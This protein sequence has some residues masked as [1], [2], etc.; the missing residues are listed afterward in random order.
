[1]SK[2][3]FS[4]LLLGAVLLPCVSGQELNESPGFLHRRAR[5]F[6]GVRLHKEKP[7]AAAAA[8]LNAIEKS[9]ALPLAP[10]FD[11]VW[12]SIGPRPTIVLDDATSAGP[13]IASGRVTSIAVDPRG[14]GDIVYIGAAHGGVWKTVDAG[15][16]WVPLTDDQPSLA[17]G[18][19][20][21]DPS[22]PDTV[23]AGT[24]EENFDDADNYF[25]AGILKTEDGGKTWKLLAS[26][27]FGGPVSAESGGAR[28]GTI[29][30][31]P[32]DS[33]ILLAA[34]DGRK[35]EHSGIYRSEDAGVTWKN[36][37]HG[38]PGTSVLFDPR[39]PA[40]LYAGLGDKSA[41]QASGIYKSTDGG[42][43][44][45]RSNRGVP[46][47]I[48]RVTLTIAASNPAILYAAIASPTTDAPLGVFK[49]TD[50]GAT[51]TSANGP[52]YCDQTCFWANTIQVSP[53]NPDLVFVA[54]LQV[55]MTRDGGKDWVSVSEG[56]NGNYI[57]WDVHAIVF[58]P[59]GRRV[60]VATDGGMYRADNVGDAQIRD[61]GWDNINDTLAITQFYPGCSGQV[62]QTDF[63]VCGTQDNGVQ[64][65]TGGSTWRMIG[66]GDGGFTAID[67][68]RPAVFYF[69]G[70]G[71]I[72]IFKSS[73]FTSFKGFLE[74]DSGLG[75]IDSDD[76]FLPPL[77]LDPAS[78]QRL[79]Y[80]CRSVFRTVDGGGR[81]QE[82]SKEL[83][84][85][86]AYTFLAV[87]PA[88]SSRVYAAASNG[89]VLVSDNATAAP[90]SVTWRTSTGLPKRGISSVVVDPMN[91]D[92]AFATAH[93]FSGFTDNLG[94]VFKTTDAGRTWRDISGD[95]PDIPANIIAFDPDS[96]QALFVGTD[97]GVFRTHDGGAAWLPV[98]LGLPRV[99]V[100]DIRL[101]PT[102]HLLRAAT[103]G[104]GMWE[105]PLTAL[106]QGLVSLRVDSGKVQTRSARLNGIGFTPNSV[107]RWNGEERKTTHV[108]FR[109]LDVAL[110]AGDLGKAGRTTVSVRDTVSGRVSNSVDV[111]TA[112]PPVI[113]RI[114]NGAIAG[115]VTTSP[116]AACPA[117]SGVSLAAGMVAT[118][119]GQNLSPMTARV[120]P[121]GIG[122]TLGGAVVEFRSTTAHESYI[123]PLLFVSPTR[124]DFQVPLNV[125]LGSGLQLDIVQGTHMSQKVCVKIDKFSPGLFSVNQQGTGQ[126]SVTA[127]SDGKLAAPAAKNARP[128]KKG[129]L[130]Q[131]L[132][133]GLGPYWQ[134]PGRKPLDTIA[135]PQAQIGGH[136]AEVTLSEARRPFVG[137][138]TVTVRIP[139]SAPSGSG[140]PVQLIAGGLKSNV[141]TIAVE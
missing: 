19:L 36:V 57:H 5:A 108:D 126:G 112:E 54:G 39:Q 139:A 98:G 1:M 141:V 64:I 17:I 15:R 71:T 58:G 125:P 110:I 129:E 103:H 130:V 40:T 86:A 72:S 53:N 23:Y 81:W 124:I 136:T 75:K 100:V 109:T 120:S 28:I 99:P 113:Q 78:P 22:S 56:A 50:A 134:E 123:A 79:F 95:L 84:Q 3:L 137:S 74:A 69:S 135:T 47:G 27:Q 76:C 104:R 106:P 87:A 61:L 85:G 73:P 44:W 13:P 9:K 65:Y 105:L 133:T 70:A 77:T 107:A 111:Q 82:V 80:G 48:G 43:T 24:G 8:R 66:G 122:Q 90:D 60:Y 30:V 101:H 21:I 37:L 128:A 18:S 121:S 49:T 119:R 127:V 41:R 33:R 55:F 31:H 117:K 29:V 6:H 83:P 97:I 92:V 96:R 59:A 16:N 20:A 26:A 7:G 42:L 102:G 11:G 2:H 67:S 46:A 10:G 12:K 45:T 32:T 93:G 51:W 118:I 91:P 138:Y 4:A 140:V 63:I 116:L 114:D 52:G 34:V 89:R 38:A 131:I 88:N 25:G 14:N 94:H 62:R 115:P 35:G 132:A 68:S